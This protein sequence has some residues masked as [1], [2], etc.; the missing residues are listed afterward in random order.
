MR[1]ACSPPGDH[2]MSTQV[3]SNDIQLISNMHLPDLVCIVLETDDR[4]GCLETWAVQVTGCKLSCCSI[5][6]HKVSRYLNRCIHV[7]CQKTI[8]FLDSKIQE[9]LTGM[10]RIRLMSCLTICGKDHKIFASKAK[11]GWDR[12]SKKNARANCRTQQNPEI[13]TLLR[14]PWFS[15]T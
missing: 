12:D 6:C 14:F 5:L 2:R 15:G 10:L 8:I 9:C 13:C 1:R 7:L 4:I 3:V 11:P